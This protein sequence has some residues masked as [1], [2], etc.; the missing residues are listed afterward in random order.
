MNN[1]NNAN[2]GGLVGDIHRSQTPT[3]TQPTQD[4]D[5]EEFEDGMRNFTVAAVALADAM[6]AK[7]GDKSITILKR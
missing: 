2:I 4:A 5:T 3:V 6:K 1:D 7:G